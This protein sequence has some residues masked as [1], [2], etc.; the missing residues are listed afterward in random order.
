MD[1]YLNA[2]KLVQTENYPDLEISLVN[3]LGLSIWAW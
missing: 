2:L 1:T 3:G